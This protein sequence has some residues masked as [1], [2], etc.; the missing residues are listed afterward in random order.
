MN[1]RKLLG[2][3]KG[4]DSI[5]SLFFATIALILLLVF[6]S[7]F[8]VLLLYTHGTPQIQIEM[9]SNALTSNLI[10]FLQDRNSAGMKN[11]ESVLDSPAVKDS[12]SKFL[13]EMFPIQMLKNDIGKFSFA[14]LK[15]SPNQNSQGMDEI[16]ARKESMIPSGLS[17]V[18]CNKADKN[19]AIAEIYV[20][21]INEKPIKV[22]LCVGK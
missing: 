4:I 10:G 14:L 17:L 21:K 12:A 18:Y 5:I 20:P 6:F 8:S 9:P 2:D 16:L 22:M 19:Q 11:W 1:I 7:V 15:T 3:K 13:E